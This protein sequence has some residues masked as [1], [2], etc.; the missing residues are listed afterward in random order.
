MTKNCWLYLLLFLFGFSC[1]EKNR[2]KNNIHQVK[3]VEAKGYVVPEE[4]MAA[5]KVILVD[6]SKLEIIPAGKLRVVGINTNI[7]PVG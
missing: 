4:S 6:Q 3:V 2:N 5:P 7:H 1:T